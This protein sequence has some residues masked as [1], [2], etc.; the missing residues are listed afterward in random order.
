MTTDFKTT[1]ELINLVSEA[2]RR[3]CPPIVF[4][5][6][7]K[8]LNGEYTMEIESEYF[9]YESNEG[10]TYGKRFSSVEEAKESHKKFSDKQVKEF[11]SKL[12]EMNEEQL[13]SQA[14]YWLKA[15]GKIK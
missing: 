14:K 3:P 13:N 4:R 9:V 5:R 12:L 6:S 11:K 2:S 1:Q 10:T 7:L 8:H 15:E